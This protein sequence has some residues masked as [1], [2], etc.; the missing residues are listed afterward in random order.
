VSQLPVEILIEIAGKAIFAEDFKAFMGVYT[1]A[2]ISVIKPGRNEI[3][4]Y[5]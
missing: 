4:K 5:A 3:V 2:A 1:D